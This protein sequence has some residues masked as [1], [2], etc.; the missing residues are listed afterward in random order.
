MERKEKEM[1][2]KEKKGKE[3]EK[4]WKERETVTSAWLYQRCCLKVYNSNSMVGMRT[5]EM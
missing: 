3:K 1:K 2:G 4:K 5:D